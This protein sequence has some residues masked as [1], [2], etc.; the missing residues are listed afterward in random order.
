[1]GRG[2]GAHRGAGDPLCSSLSKLHEAHDSARRAPANSSQRGHSRVA[3][4]QEARTE[5]RHPQA[6]TA[7]GYGGDDQAQGHARLAHAHAGA[8]PTAVRAPSWTFSSLR[9]GG[10]ERLL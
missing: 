7:H 8:A 5:M 1:M 10:R 2:G 6:E 3:H 4:A 9:K